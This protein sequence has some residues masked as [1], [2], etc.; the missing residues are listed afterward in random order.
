MQSL[1]TNEKTGEMKLTVAL[2][3]QDFNNGWRLRIADNQIRISAIDTYTKLG[4]TMIEDEPNDSI[5]S[6]F[7]NSSSNNSTLFDTSTTY[8]RK[9]Y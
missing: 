5:P 1:L 8:E 9:I 2:S 3:D 4:Y 6:A 7:N